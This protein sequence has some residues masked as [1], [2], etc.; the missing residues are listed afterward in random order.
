MANCDSTLVVSATKAD[1]ARTDARPASMR[2]RP[3][4]RLRHLFDDL[5][6]GN[7][8]CV[9]VDLIEAVIEEVDHLRQLIDGPPIDA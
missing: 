8:I 4:D 1:T 7:F 2:E 9:D 5:N 3:T 6:E